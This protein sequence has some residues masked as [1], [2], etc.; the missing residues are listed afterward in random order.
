ML[1]SVLALYKTRVLRILDRYSGLEARETQLITD[2]Q[3]NHDPNA[4]PDDIRQALAALKDDGFSHRR[5][6]DLRGPVWQVTADGH[7]AVAAMA[8]EEDQ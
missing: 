5:I 2:F 8:L 3:V 7:R 6:D 4:R 1:T